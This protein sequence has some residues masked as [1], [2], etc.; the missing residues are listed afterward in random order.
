MLLLIPVFV[1]AVLVLG[2]RY[3]SSSQAQVSA[4]Q[5]TATPQAEVFLNNTSLGKTPLYSDKLKPEEYSLKLVPDSTMGLFNFEEKITLRS[6]ILTVVDRVFKATEAESETSIVSLEQ[7]GNKNA[8]EI[9]IVSSPEGAEV[10]LDEAAHGVTP[11]LLKDVSV[12]DHQIT[13][14]KEGYNSKTLR[15]HPTEGYR[16]TASTKLSISQAATPSPQ[17]APSPESPTDRPT[18]TPSKEKS[19]EATTAGK[20]R[21]LETPTGFLRVRA[22]PST[23]SKELTRVSPDDTFTLLDKKEGWLKITL[24]DGREGWISS[25]YAQEE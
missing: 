18:P 6:G 2:Y 11:L 19:K 1:G 13:I 22:E 9:S 7:L 8:V 23:A 24:Q 4:L 5:V 12:S 16:L 17:S 15:V 25:Q 20:V 3:I 10:K 21:I 14:A